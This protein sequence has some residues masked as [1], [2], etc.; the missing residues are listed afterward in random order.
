MKNLLKFRIVRVDLDG[1]NGRDNHPAAE[2][3]GLVVRAFAMRTI[4]AD[5]EGD[6][7][8][9]ADDAANDDPARLDDAIAI[10]SCVTDGGQLL[11]LLDHELEPVAPEP[12]FVASR[13][14]A[15]VPTVAPLQDFA[16][17]MRACTGSVRVTVTDGDASAVSPKAD[18][19]EGGA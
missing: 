19:D 1:F 16:D 3:V 8:V 11:D 17:A 15:A 6:D 12:P 9:T 7:D 4:Y 10:W 14:P 5:A 2:H 13:G 18:D